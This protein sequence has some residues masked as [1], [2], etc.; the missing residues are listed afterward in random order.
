MDSTQSLGYIN[1]LSKNRKLWVLLSFCWLLT[2]FLT[3]IHEQQHQSADDIQ[4]QFCLSNLNN[5]PFVSTLGFTFNQSEKIQFSFDESYRVEIS[6][7]PLTVLNRGPP[8]C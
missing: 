3:T 8:N 6:T 2:V 7:S 1:R 4:C 5:T